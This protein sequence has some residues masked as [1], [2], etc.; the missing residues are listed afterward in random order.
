[1]DVSHIDIKASLENIDTVG[2]TLYGFCRSL[3]LSARSCSTCPDSHSFR[4]GRDN[5]TFCTFRGERVDLV[6]SRLFSFM[7][8]TTCLV[9]EHNTPRRGAFGRE[10]EAQE[11]GATHLILTLCC[12]AVNPFNAPESVPTLTSSEYILRI[13]GSNSE[14]VEGEIGGCFINI[15]KTQ[16]TNDNRR[17][18]GGQ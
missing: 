1:M 13:R 2:L 7:N 15:V 16:E 3:W 5:K 12:M 9:V 8:P 4:R 14:S 11:G 6:E 10:W 18:G 17:E